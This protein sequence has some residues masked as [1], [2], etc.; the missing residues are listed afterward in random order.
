MD[1]YLSKNFPIW[2]DSQALVLELE[3][4]VKGFARYHKY[5]IGSELRL[6]AQ[7]VLNYVSHAINQSENRTHWLQRLSL[8][9]EELKLLIQTAKMRHVFQSFKHFEVIARLAVQVAKQSKAWLNK[10]QTKLQR[11]D[12]RT[13]VGQT[14]RDPNGQ[15]EQHDV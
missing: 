15:Q 10:S 2:R 12:A 3:R 1:P 6:G 9:I 13:R 11:A 5:T 14:Q 8:Q 7:R 4:A